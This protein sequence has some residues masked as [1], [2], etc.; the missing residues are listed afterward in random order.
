MY[1]K[2]NDATANALLTT[3]LN[4]LSGGVGTPSA[5]FYTGSPPANVGAI[6]SQILLGTL[7]CSDPVGS[8]ASRTLTFGAIADD[9]AADSG[10]TAGFVRILDGDDVARVDLDCGLDGSGAAVIMNTTTVVQGGPIKVTS[11]TITL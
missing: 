6:T 5:K 1:I 11:L 8:V 4:D 7:A 2:T 9:A 10:G 3:L